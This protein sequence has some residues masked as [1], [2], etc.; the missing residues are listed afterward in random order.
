MVVPGSF[1]ANRQALGVAENIAAVDRQMAPVGN[2]INRV[3]SSAVPPSST[4]LFTLRLTCASLT[5]RADS[6]LGKECSGEK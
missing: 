6:P 1:Q 3:N 2:L 4:L 5:T